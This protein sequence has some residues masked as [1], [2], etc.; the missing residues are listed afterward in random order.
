MA[1]RVIE[2]KVPTQWRCPVAVAA[3]TQGLAVGTG[4]WCAGKFG[5]HFI[6][7]GQ[8]GLRRMSDSVAIAMW[9]NHYVAGP[10]MQCL[11]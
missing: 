4:E 3:S 7:G 2:L 8:F 1:S 11:V 5:K 9:K 10:K 6:G